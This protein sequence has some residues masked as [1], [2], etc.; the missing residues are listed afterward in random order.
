MGDFAVRCPKC[1]S[2]QVSVYRD[3]S[4]R[5]APYTRSGEPILKCGTC[6]KEM[7]GEAVVKEVQR[8]R[9]EWEA[10]KSKAAPA[11]PSIDERARLAVEQARQE[12]LKARAAAATGM[13]AQI[14][15]IAVEVASWRTVVRNARQTFKA[16]GEDFRCAANLVEIDVACVERLA[17]EAARDGMSVESLKAKLREATSIAS[18]LPLRAQRA[19]DTAVA[20]AQVTGTRPWKA[21]PRTSAA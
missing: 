11:E 18:R 16:N 13:A 6:G 20:V 17:E 1:R 3:T 14:A 10:S 5:W 2:Q 8:Q 12:A 15:Q 7:Y 9:A 4:A 19:V 21:C